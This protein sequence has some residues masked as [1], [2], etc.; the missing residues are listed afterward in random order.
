MTGIQCWT[1]VWLIT[2]RGVQAD[3]TMP[4]LRLKQALGFNFSRSTLNT[5]TLF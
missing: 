4:N 5:V 3:L 2:V 1:I